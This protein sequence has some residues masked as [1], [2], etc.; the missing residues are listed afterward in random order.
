MQD[1]L[2]QFNRG[3]TTLTKP[4]PTYKPDKTRPVQP[5]VYTRSNSKRS[6]SGNGSGK[7][8]NRNTDNVILQ[9]LERKVIQVSKKQLKGERSYRAMEVPCL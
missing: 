7:N 3:S 5:L 9:M 1:K 8:N 4:P 2:T 6:G